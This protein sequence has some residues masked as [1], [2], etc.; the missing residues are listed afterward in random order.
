MLSLIDIEQRVSDIYDDII[1]I[2]RHI[3]Q[4]PELGY[5]EEKTSK[6]VAKELRQCG[7]EV[8]EGVGGY[9]VVGLL[10]GQ[11]PG[12][13]LLLR[14]DMDAL[15]IQEE[16]GLP[17]ASKIPGKMHACGHDLHTAILLGA[18]RVLSQYKETMRGNIKF[19]FQPAEE[20]NPQGGAKA[21]IEAGVLENPKV[22]YALALHVWPDLKVGEIGLAKGPVSAQSDRLF[23]KILGKSGHASAPHQ[24]IDAMVAAA[25]VMS[26]LQTIISRR[27]DPRD[28]VVITLG[29]ISGGQRYNVICDKVELEGTVRIMTPGYENLMP[30]LIKQVVEGTASAHGAR[31]SMEYI[32]GY[33][34]VI[35]DDKLTSLVEKFLNSQ[36]EDITVKQI[37]QDTSGEDFSFISRKVPSVYMKLGS[38]PI[39][40][41][42]FMPLHNSKAIFDEK[43]IYFGIKALVASSSHLLTV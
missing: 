3:H 4:Y 27:V 15:P 1:K 24:G 11:K 5:E 34:M 25:H 41:K 17:Y 16:T 32:K 36:L 6:L 21:M 42:D 13:T 29:K 7:I 2:R 12:K 22:D 14:A 31:S 33:P 37:G 26:S 23:I 43:S 18:S 19:V 39:G 30:K 9:G 40:A 8:V 35:N 20:C 10:K 28:S 38:T